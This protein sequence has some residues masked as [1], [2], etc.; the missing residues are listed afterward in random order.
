MR[1]LSTS[2]FIFGLTSQIFAQYQNV[3]INK[4]ATRPEEVTISINP[5]NPQNI[6]AGANI[7]S[8]FYS[9]DAG[10]TWDEGLLP[11]DTY[12]DPC[13][14]FDAD[15]RAYYAHLSSTWES[16][17]VRHSDDGG[18]TWSQPVQLRGPSSDSARPGPL[19]QTSLQDKE[20]LATDMTSSP[21]RGN[22]YASWTD[23][24]KYGSRSPNDSS[25]IAFARSTNRGVSFEPFVRVSDDI[26]NAVDSDSTMEGAVPA[27]GPNGEIYIAWSGPKGLYFDAS[28]DGG[29]TFGK[30]RVLTN[31][32]GGWDFDISGIMRCNGLP[33]TCC[34]ISQS[35][36]RGTV[37]VNWVDF[38]NG[39]ADVF[40]M[41]ST[42]RGL[43]WSQP[44]RV[45][46]DQIRNGKQQFFTWMSVDPITGEV[47]IIFYDRRKYSSDST[48]V[49][50]AFST[51][52]GKTFNNQYISDAAFYP[53]ATVFFG[54]YIG[55]ASY[56]GIIHPIWTELMNGILTSQTTFIDHNP[57]GVVHQE[58]PVKIFLYQNFPN[59]FTSRSRSGDK[60]SATIR[61]A[62]SEPGFT[63]LILFDI[64]GREVK[65]FVHEWQEQGEYSIPFSVNSLSNGNYIYQLRSG[66]R[67][68]SKFMTIV[69]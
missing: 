30:D 62:L 10:K 38:R 33:I 34:D 7:R 52:G 58:K 43:S 46:D 5:A 2:F 36:Y 64:V 37:Y 17:K 55:I 44:Q 21:F 11:N 6:I 27:V 42:D 63:E 25:V 40:I 53:T 20:W 54:D 56:N 8:F 61:Y 23:F 24:S 29:K 66:R 69:N 51:D 68:L 41:K 16:I 28:W 50:L 57:I 15:G 39:D 1:L 32:P 47:A 12:G 35:Q 9:T 59:P 48:D 3:Q 67:V 19:S 18:K 65:T 45:N 22:V 14:I 60:A 26:G 49:Y 31:T 4:P 13:V